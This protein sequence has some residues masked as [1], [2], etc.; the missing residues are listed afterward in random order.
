MR[1]GIGTDVDGYVVEALIGKGGMGE[2]YKAR[3][4]DGINRPV[5]LKILPEILAGDEISRERFRHEARVIGSLDHPNILP[6]YRFGVYS[7][8]PWMAMRFVDG[9]DLSSHLQRGATSDVDVLSVLRSVAAALDYAHTQGVLHRDVKPQNI[10]VSKSGSAYLADF[11]ISKLIEGEARI[12]RP[13]LIDTVTGNIIGSAAYMAPEQVQGR[14]LGPATDVYSLA[15]VCYEWLVGRRPFADDTQGGVLH[16][17]AFE[18]VPTELLRG[19]SDGV[20]SVLRKGMS[21]DPGAR[22]QTATALVDELARELD[23]NRTRPQRPRLSW[24]LSGLTVA[25][26]CVLLAAWVV[27]ASPFSSSPSP[28]VPGPNP[29]LPIPVSS[30]FK[31]TAPE[32]SKV[33]IA[34]PS[35]GTS[36]AAANHPSADEQAERALKLASDG[37]WKAAWPALDAAEQSLRDRVREQPRDVFRRMSLTNALWKDGYFAY[38]FAHDQNRGLAKLEEAAAVVE[39]LAP[40]TTDEQRALIWQTEILL[41]DALRGKNE[42]QR[43]KEQLAKA[44]KATQEMSPEHGLPAGVNGSAF[45]TLRAQGKIALAENDLAQAKTYFASALTCITALIKSGTATQAQV[46]DQV[47]TLNSLASVATAQNDYL[48]AVEHSKRAIEAGRVLQDPFRTTQVAS[49]QTLAVALAAL[50]KKDEAVAAYEAFKKAA[51]SVEIDGMPRGINA[52]V[53]DACFSLGAYAVA[54]GHFEV[55][56]KDYDEAAGIARTILDKR[57]DDMGMRA[58]L[59]EF[60]RLSGFYRYYN[61]TGRDQGIATMRAADEEA[62]KLDHEDRWI[63]W[64]ARQDLANMLRKSGEGEEADRLQEEARIIADAAPGDS[65]LPVGYGVRPLASYME[66]GMA[67]QSGGKES[68]ARRAFEHAKVI[69]LEM[70]KVRHGEPWLAWQLDRLRQFKILQ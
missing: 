16:K 60:L 64:V 53:L 42:N 39:L 25:A 65:G 37:D 51:G 49:H 8:I 38:W 40:A 41:A 12:E 10:L 67:A 22:F 47:D 28:A 4:V 69:A 18:P 56:I 29:S 2:V 17:H 59:A 33:P 11:G 52:Q 50:K 57:P 1:L 20:K 43:A 26:A 24:A 48:A 46:N 34:Y 23:G 15:V 62:R 14:Q 19:R 6:L 27:R 13:P 5:A 58:R 32:V 54:D 45:A 30:P 66:I 35:T 55:A 63:V 7:G 21:K 70:D 44:W 68:E 36:P 3:E 9:G 31:P 61:T